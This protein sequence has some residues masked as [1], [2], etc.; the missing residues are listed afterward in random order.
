ML[1]GALHTPVCM[2]VCMYC[3]TSSFRLNVNRKLLMYPAYISPG[4]GRNCHIRMCVQD[5]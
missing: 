5:E 4:V 3:K 1:H 2:Y